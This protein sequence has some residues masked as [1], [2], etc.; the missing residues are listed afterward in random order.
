MEH[1][2]SRR[3]RSAGSQYLP[4]PPI[5]PLPYLGVHFLHYTLRDL[6]PLLPL[7]RRPPPWLPTCNSAAWTVRSYPPKPTYYIVHY[8]VHYIGHYV[9]HKIVHYIVHHI[10]HHIVHYLVQ[11]RSY[12]PNPTRR[13]SPRF[14]RSRE[15][16]ARRRSAPTRCHRARL[17]PPCPTCCPNGPSTALAPTWTALAPT[18]SIPGAA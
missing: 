4:I 16:R 5:L 1:G 12:R 7:R 8:I 15:G 6:L 17:G 14:A 10:V 2:E 11:V 9:V 13:H 3:H 18:W